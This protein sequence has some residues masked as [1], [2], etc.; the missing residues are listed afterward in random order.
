MA[1]KGKGREIWKLQ[2]TESS[3]FYTMTVRKGAEKLEI[4]K[5]DPILRKHVLYKQSKL[6]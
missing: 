6:K 5:Y 4:M 2:S 1:A 3:H